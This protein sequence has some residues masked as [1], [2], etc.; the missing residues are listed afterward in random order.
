MSSPCPTLLAARFPPATSPGLSP[1]SPRRPAC[2]RPSELCLCLPCLARGATLIALALPLVVQMPG[3]HRHGR[4]RS[5]LWDSPGNAP[6]REFGL[7]EPTGLVLPAR[8]S[9]AKFGVCW[10]CTAG[11]AT[12]VELA[13]TTAFLDVP[14]PLWGGFWFV[15]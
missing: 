8:A 10:P 12:I 7:R 2:R 3:C 1:R 11:V 15:L 6:T 14:L 13:S 4:C 9:R 5:Q